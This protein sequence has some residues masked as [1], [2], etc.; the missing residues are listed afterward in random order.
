MKADVQ[1]TKNTLA[2]SLTELLKSTSFAKISVE[3]ICKN[4]RLSKRTF[5]NYFRDKH[6]LVAYIWM[7]L[8]EQSTQTDGQP[9]SLEDYLTKITLYGSVLDEFFPKA[10]EYNGQNN[11]RETMFKSS[12]ESHINL[13]KQN[14]W[15]DRI[16]NEV[17][18]LL[19][20][21]IHGMLGYCEEMLILHR[22]YKADKVI[23][24]QYY[25]GADAM[26]FLPEK[27]KPLILTVN[28]YQGD[29][30]KSS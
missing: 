24:E 17:K 5:Y 6:D 9:S 18:H 1:T 30:S 28:A 20:F 2:D 15:G 26:M 16:D 13:M 19:K 4:C 7:Q 25:T 14:G 21:Y 3:D 27:L 29:T 11:L 8:L 12:Y 10:F 23:Q 22:Q